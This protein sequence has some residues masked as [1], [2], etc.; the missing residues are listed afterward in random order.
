MTFEF[1][2][3]TRI[4][5]GPGCSSQISSEAHKLGS[6]IL[7]ITG[8]K[9]YFPDSASLESFDDSAVANYSVSG[10]PT[11]E[12]VTGGVELAKESGADVIVSIGGGSVIDTGKAI[13]AL[14]K[15]EGLPTD[16]LEVIGKGQT[17]TSQSLPCIAVPT[18]AGTGAEVTKNAVL[19]SISKGVKVSLRSPYL[20]PRVAV[21]DPTLVVS[22]GPQLT[23]STGCDALTQCIESF[24]SC[25]ATPFSDIVCSEGI[26]RA[27]R[28]LPR[29]CSSGCDLTA[30]TDLSIAAL[31]SGIALA[32]SGLGAVHGF[33][34]VIGGLCGLPH[35]IICAMLLRPVLAEVIRSDIA[36]NSATPLHT[37]LHMLASLLSAR[38]TDSPESIIESLDSIYKCLGSALPVSGTQRID[39]ALFPD[40]VAGTRNSSSMKGS[41][42]S[43]SDAIL[44]SLLERVF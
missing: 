43:I 34:A 30:R 42:V 31:L 4:L 7:L 23:A 36:Q 20:F 15:N 11:V 2:I 26:V 40:I 25:K 41:P 16:Y 13:A 3:P 33:A 37:K 18:T 19:R 28:S 1:N 6:K 24:I 17:L 38:R 44:R 10:E 39:R 12:M 22:L 35:G 27:T 32:N 14:V 9:H 5:F 21:V 8:K 29:A